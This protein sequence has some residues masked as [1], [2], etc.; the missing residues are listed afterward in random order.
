ML[1]GRLPPLNAK[2]VTQRPPGSMNADSMGAK[3]STGKSSVGRP[4]RELD[5]NGQ[6][7][8]KARAKRAPKPVEE[9]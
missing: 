7:I 2:N 9:V 8:R 1:D 5:A 4:P 6:P 3:K